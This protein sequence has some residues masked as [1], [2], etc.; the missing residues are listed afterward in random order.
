MGE[1]SRT[2]EDE[3]Q[4]EGTEKCKIRVL[5]VGRPGASSGEIL[6]LGVWRQRRV[7]KNKRMAHR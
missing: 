3:E 7:R 1:G 4:T 5:V 6:F 2:T